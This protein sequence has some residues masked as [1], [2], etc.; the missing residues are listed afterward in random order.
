M[1]ITLTSE[2]VNYVDKHNA[3]LNRTIVLDRTPAQ[4]QARLHIGS[5]V[6]GAFDANTLTHDTSFFGSANSRG[7]STLSRPVTGQ[8]DITFFNYLGKSVDNNL[9]EEVNTTSGLS[10]AGIP[11]FCNAKRV[12]GNTSANILTTC[13]ASVAATQTRLGGGNLGKVTVVFEVAGGGNVNP[14]RVD[15]A[16][17]GNF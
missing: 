3:F 11:A 13:F 12:H 5:R 10:P 9:I 8:V 16:L 4:F 6:H 15:F 2:G 14:V 17:F 1:P 7:M